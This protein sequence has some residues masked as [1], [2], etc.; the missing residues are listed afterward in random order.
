M[1]KLPG[2]ALTNSDILKYA[3]I[4]KIPNFRGVF[5]RNELPKT[6]P[7]LKEAAIINLDNKEGPGSHWVA[8]KKN[9]KKIQY[10]DSFGNVRPPIDLNEYFGEEKINYNYKKYQDFNTFICGHL[11]LKFLCNQLQRKDKFSLIKN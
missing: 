6:G 3:S 10:F 11:C 7:F 5:M 1:I 2:K 9:G 8:Y 4:L